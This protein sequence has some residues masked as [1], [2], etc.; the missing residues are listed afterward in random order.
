MGLVSKF[1]EFR[2]GNKKKEAEEPVDE[3]EMSF[4]DHL[5]ELRWHLM[6]SLIAILAFGVYFFIYRKWFV[7]EIIMVPFTSDAPIN[8]FLCQI[9]FCGEE[10]VIDYQV[11]HP[12][13]LFLKSIMISFVGGL[14]LSFPYILWEMWRFIKPGLHDH[15]RKGTRWIVFVMS[16]LF[17][18][19]I[20]FS[21]FIILPF[22]IRFLATFELFGEI[23]IAWRI[24][25]VLSFFAQI[26]LAGGIL[27]EMPI[28][29]Y[30]LAK[31][32]VITPEFLVRYRRHAIVVLL[33]ISA[34]ITPPDVLSQV[35]IFIPLLLLY[36][37]SI[38]VVKVVHRNKER[39]LA[40]EKEEEAKMREAALTQQP[41]SNGSES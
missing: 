11:L 13:E 2:Q 39:A 31:I 12:T 38:R 5:E 8:Q 20:A 23:S 6:R 21:Y 14:V 19:G 33:L 18:A 36:Q 9:G 3:S 24:G 4:L 34:I 41:P 27:F 29:A 28:L 10:V 37:V 16:L 1:K 35:L 40:K 32:G 7:E 15:E 22:S 30:F 25:Y 26:I 17:F